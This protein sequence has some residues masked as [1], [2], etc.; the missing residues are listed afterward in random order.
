MI[1]SAA[2]DNHSDLD[3]NNSGSIGN[4]AIAGLLKK[5]NTLKSAISANSVN[6]ALKILTKEKFIGSTFISD[7][8]KL[9]VLEIYVNNNAYQREIKKIQDSG[10]ID[11]ENMKVLDQTFKIMEG[12]TDKDYD[13]NSKEIIKDTL[14]VRTNHGKLLPDAGYQ[15]SDSDISG[16][17]S[18][19][20]RYMHSYKAINKL[21]LNCHPFEVLTTL[22]NLKGIE[23]EPQNNPIRV[24]DGITKEKPFYSST[25]LML[26]PTGILFAVPLNGLVKDKRK[27]TLKNNRKVDFVM[28]PKNLPLFESLRS[29]IMRKINNIF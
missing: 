17:N 7:G 4:I 24:K 13:I 16:Y 11:L 29:I 5:T 9:I 25:I 6:K 8:N 26:T 20:K 22:K 12:I 21:G 2:L 15:E 23:K 14:I 27:L 10:K 19:Q 3:D 28:L 1:V 18:S